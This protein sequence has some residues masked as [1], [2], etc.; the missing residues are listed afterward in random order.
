MK[1]IFFRKIKFNGYAVI[2]R[3]NRWFISSKNLVE[4]GNRI[5]TE[6]YV[7]IQAKGKLRIGNSFFINS[8]SR[9]VSY[10]DIEIGDNVVIA[11]FVSILDHDHDSKFIN[12]NI[13]FSGYVTKP[14]RIGNN[15]WIGDKVTI[16]KG[17]HIGENVII[18]ANSVVTKDIPPN[19]LAAGCPCKVIRNIK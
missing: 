4:I 7:E 3:K 16:I 18:G 1:I 5:Q 9:I 19:S 14:I 17:V 2:G 15:V 10:D 8:Y 13:D 6:D 12:G 11:Q